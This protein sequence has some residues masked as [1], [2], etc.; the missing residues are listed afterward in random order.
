MTGRVTTRTAEEVCV[1]RDPRL[2]V[3]DCVRVED[4][5]DAADLD[6]LEVGACASITTEVE[7]TG[8]EA[9][10]EPADEAACAAG[11]LGDGNDD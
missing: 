4:V 3:S 2:A 11:D 1:S 8:A 9:R 10:V 5:A 6:G 7:S